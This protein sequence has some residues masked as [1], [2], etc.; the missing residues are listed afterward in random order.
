V[1][2]VNW[3]PIFRKKWSNL[4]F[5]DVKEVTNGEWHLFEA[6]VYL[7]GAENGYIYKGQNRQP[8]R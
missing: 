1:Q 6:Q 7:N 5:V 2:V 3:Q 4:R 8:V